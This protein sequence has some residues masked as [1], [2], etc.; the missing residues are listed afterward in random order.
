MAILQSV[1]MLF[2]QILAVHSHMKPL[3]KKRYNLAD[4]AEF[5][6]FVDLPV[7]I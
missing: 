4:L 1:S 6:G 3:A 7:P 2:D 5:E